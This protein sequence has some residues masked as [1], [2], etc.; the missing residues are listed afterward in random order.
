VSKESLD[1]GARS[2]TS[3][4]KNGKESVGN[5]LTVRWMDCASATGDL[6]P[7]VKSLKALVKTSF[8]KMTACSWQYLVYL[9]DQLLMQDS[10]KH[11]AMWFSRN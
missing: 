5:A 9:L 10:E 3:I 2:H 8:Q 11:L 7:I 1:R 6:L 4:K